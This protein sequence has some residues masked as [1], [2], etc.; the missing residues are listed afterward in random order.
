[1]KLCRKF[2]TNI[3]KIM[4]IGKNLYQILRKNP[5]ISENATSE[6]RLS[7]LRFRTIRF[8]ISE[9]FTVSYFLVVWIVREFDCLLRWARLHQPRGAFRTWQ[10]AP[11]RRGSIRST[12]YLYQ[13]QPRLIKQS[14][15]TFIYLIIRCK[16]ALERSWLQTKNWWALYSFF[17]SGCAGCCAISAK[18][19]CAAR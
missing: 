13:P 5:G 8:R 7:K 2:T 1:M 11:K 10:R 9:K 16:G 14:K 19:N 17:V 12:T 15:S 18:E 6:I 4:L 3:R